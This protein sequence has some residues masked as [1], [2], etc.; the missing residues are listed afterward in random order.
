MRLFGLAL[1]LIFTIFSR[2]VR[3]GSFQSIDF[4]T[5]VRV[6]NFIAKLDIQ[7]LE[8]LLEDIGVLAS[9]LISVI[10]VGVLIF[11]TRSLPKAIFI[12]FA[13]GLMILA[14][15]YGKSAVHHPAPPFFLLKNPTTIFPTYHVWEQFSY[16]SGHAARAVF[17]S[18]IAFFLF[19]KRLWV[20]IAMGVYVGLIVLSR[21]YLGHHWLSDVVGGV[22]LGSGFALLATKEAANRR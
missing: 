16:P 9:P 17:L 2:Q 10:V 11:W 21:I 13:F 4:D 1:L 14:E 18:L 3:T 7:R 5:T 8:G 20:G 12:L 6:Q 15:I 22:L 19:K